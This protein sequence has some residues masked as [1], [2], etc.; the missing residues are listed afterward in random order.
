MLYWE[1]CYEKTFDHQFKSS[2]ILD[3]TIFVP[4]KR[5][6]HKWKENFFLLQLKQKTIVFHLPD[7]HTQ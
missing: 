2:E 1:T 6:K 3:Y 5:K 7:Y 4:L